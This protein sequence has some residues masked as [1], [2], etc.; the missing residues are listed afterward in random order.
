MSN[1][2]HSNAVYALNSYVWQVLRANLGWAAADYGNRTPI[3]TA[4]Q[5]P[6]FLQ[7]NKPFVVYGSAINKIDSTPYTTSE[8]IAY[9]VY[10]T[11]ATEVDKVMRVLVEALRW[12]DVTARNVND[13][14]VVEGQARTGGK[15]PVSFHTIYV[16]Q[17]TSAGPQAAEG[18][19]VDSQAMVSTQYVDHGEMKIRPED[20]P[21]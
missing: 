13:W 2:V 19:W 20:F 21:A 17:A 1:T 6:E 15:R 5:Q 14:L 10:A 16:V 4:N 7:Y 8:T 11:T 12:M 3:I 9:T 18:G